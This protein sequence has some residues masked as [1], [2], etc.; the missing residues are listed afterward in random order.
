M[1]NPQFVTIYL[2]ESMWV[3]LCVWLMK[4]GAFP[5][6]FSIIFFYFHSIYWINNEILL[7]FHIIFMHIYNLF[8][9][10]F[11]SFLYKYPKYFCGYRKLFVWNKKKLIKT[12]MF[13]KGIKIILYFLILILN[14][15]SIFSYFSLS[16]LK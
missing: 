9:F 4:S 7:L 2:S 10:F 8:F 14:V 13:N 5:I 1:K 15:S 16:V 11:S 6:I 3:S 12:F